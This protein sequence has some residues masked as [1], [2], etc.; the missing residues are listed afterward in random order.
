MGAVLDGHRSMKAPQSVTSTRGDCCAK[1]GS[2]LRWDSVTAD[3][4]QMILRDTNVLAI[5][6]KIDDTNNRRLMF[7]NEILKPFR[8][9]EFVRPNSR[10]DSLY[11]LV[12]HD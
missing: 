8:G 7:L 11:T 3:L 9:T 10:V 4:L 1:S 2:D 6:N 12:H 5:T